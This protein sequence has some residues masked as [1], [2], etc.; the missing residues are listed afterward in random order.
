MRSI[1]IALFKM[2]DLCTDMELQDF[3][4]TSI[5]LNIYFILTNLTSN[6]L[7]KDARILY[8]KLKNVHINISYLRIYGI[9]DI[10]F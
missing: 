7:Q 3:L 5:L 4:I 10:S 9:F 1:I 8:N 2:L 6:F